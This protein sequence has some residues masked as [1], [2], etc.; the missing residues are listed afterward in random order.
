M[1]RPRT[2]TGYGWSYS[3]APHGGRD[4]VTVW[5]NAP[6][7]PSEHAFRLPLELCPDDSSAM[8]RLL[9]FLLRTIR[10]TRITTRNE[11]NEQKQG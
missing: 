8:I 1:Y 4:T 9:D 11:S 6:G 5:D 7:A 2:D 10:H 3:I